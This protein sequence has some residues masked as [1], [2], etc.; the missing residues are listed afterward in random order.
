M[1]ASA[2]AAVERFERLYRESPD[3][4]GYRT[5]EYER[6]K[7][8][9][10][11]A[12]L[13]RRAHGLC[14]EVGCSI[15]VFTGQLAARCE[16]VVAIDFSFCALQLARRHLQGVRNVDLLRAGFPE[17]TPPGSW[18][19]IVCSE[20][21]Y[22][23]QRPALEEAIGW[24]KAQLGFGASVLAVSW[25]GVGQEEPLRGDEVH[26]LLERELAEWHVLDARRRGYRLDRFDGR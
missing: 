9:A 19:L 2:P 21:L 4:W 6:E 16:H 5:S 26:D 20:V 24:I 11:L 10:T 7:Y 13:P 22:Y 23:L 14:L 18:D 8:A 17:E 12:A 1:T 25:R 3:P 15:G